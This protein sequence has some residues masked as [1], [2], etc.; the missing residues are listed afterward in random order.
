[1]RSD[2]IVANEE[3]RARRVMIVDPEGVNNG[4]FD[5]RI[6]RAKAT[7]IGLDL[8][9]V[10]V[11]AKTT[12]P[13]CKIMDLGKYKYEQSKKKQHKNHSDQT[14]EIMFKLQT[15]EHDIEIKKKK[16]IELLSKDY[17][18]KFG[19]KLKGR[20]RAHHQNALNMVKSHAD[21]LSSSGKYDNIASSDGMIF[22]TL[23]PI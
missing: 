13:V 14:K 7:E 8:V 18:V 6:A 11:D 4:E 21:Q 20:E 19:I 2:N 5:L 10:G 12:F 1:M 16:V 15:S 23:N 3:I 22:V 17:K 9:Q